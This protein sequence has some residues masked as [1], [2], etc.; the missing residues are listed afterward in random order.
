MGDRSASRRRRPA[1]LGPE[2][3]ES[4]VL[5]AVGHLH[6]LLPDPVGP[7]VASWFGSAVAI[8]NDYRVVSAPESS[9]HPNKGQVFV[10]DS[11]NTLIH[12]I[13][14]PDPE[15][16]VDF[17]RDID[18]DGDLIVV[19]GLVSP[20][21]GIVSDGAF[22]V[23]DLSDSSPVLL[24]SGRSI[25]RLL[26]RSV[27]ISGQTVV[28]GASDTVYVYKLGG[29]TPGSEITPTET[30]VSP[31]GSNTDFGAAVDMEGSTIAVGAPMDDTTSSDAGAVYLFRFQSSTAVL[32]ASLRN[33][34]GMTPQY[35]NLGQ[36]LAIDGN[37]VAIGADGT[38]V[39]VAYLYE[40][41]ATPPIVDVTTPTAV[42]HPT[43]GPES[44]GFA[45]S[46]DISG[47]MVVVGAPQARFAASPPQPNTGAAYLFDVTGATGGSV[48]DDFVFV[49]NH[50]DSGRDDAFGSGVAIH[51]DELVIGALGADVAVSA[52]GSAYL[53]DVSAVNPG[54]TINTPTHTLAN[55]TPSDFDRFGDAVDASGDLVV[56]GAYN[57]DVT[58]VG[59]GS[60]YVFNYSDGSPS[61]LA[62]IY[63]PLGEEDDEFGQA[64]GISGNRVVVGVPMKD[65]QNDNE[66]GM[67]YVYDVTGLTPGSVLNDPFAILENPTPDAGDLFGFSVAIDGDTVVVGAPDDNSIPFQ[68]GGAYAYD[69]S[70]VTSGTTLSAPTWDLQTSED[71]RF[72]QSVDIDNGKIVV[73]RVRGPDSRSL[74]YYYDIH[75]IAPGVVAA[76]TMVIAHPETFE[77][78]FG[79]AVAIDD[80]IVVVGDPGQGSGVSYVFDLTSGAPVLWATID[81]PDASFARV[82]GS[83]AIEGAAVILGAS[84]T[85]PSGRRGQAY[86]ISLEGVE[87]GSI[88]TEPSQELVSP[89]SSNNDRYGEA[90]SVMNGRVFIGAPDDDTQ[91]FSQGV[92][93]VFGVVVD[94]NQDGILDC[95]DINA[96]TNEIATGG[97]Q[98]TF[99]LTGDG[100]VNLADRDLW[101]QIAGSGTIGTSYLLGDANLDG[102]VDGQ[103]FLAWNG[104][105]F[106]VSANWCDGDFN[107]DG[108]VDG[109]DFIIWNNNKFMS[110]GLGQSHSDDKG[111]LH[112]RDLDAWFDA[113][114]NDF[115]EK[116]SQEDR[117]VATARAS[118]TTAPTYYDSLSTRRQPHSQDER[119]LEE[120]D[121]ILNCLW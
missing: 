72:G 102:N 19:G 17:G 12:T 25:D 104:N 62:R 80:D 56:V 1:R 105:K 79:D 14:N 92:V 52:E 45:E 74:V 86:R 4:R 68:D 60:V 36:S 30:L 59:S 78:S 101:L 3:L 9:V 98:S 58:A 49:E 69:L 6:S 96:L 118:A 65:Q 15:F 21:S 87:L 18:V 76:P 37:R 47:E 7:Q 23:Y 50:S 120:F 116:V 114:A 108:F 99:D 95:T 82:G 91:N 44:F 48:V 61:L 53:Y 97:N 110:S 89:S 64:V 8:S 115:S 24:A 117:F 16:S 84:E 73:G 70:T 77:F 83:V 42:L 100:V 88:I 2:Q 63:P 121:E 75:T 39:P 33:D 107:A 119:L 43:N 32:V 71:G 57:D 22:Y 28:V 5:L 26:G 93:H 111:A 85:V 51:Q 46:I 41:P 113:Y 38:S 103:D 109:Q 29:V 10:Y 20:D 40:I 54:T 106:S 11:S 27:A 55:V 112:N 67:A 13:N 66:V 34:D 81:I 31:A 94:F 35:R 90:V